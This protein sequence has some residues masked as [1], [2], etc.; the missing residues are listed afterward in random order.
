VINLN[1]TMLKIYHNPACK[2]SRAGL[3]F[4]QNTG[5]PFEVVAY[6]KNPITEQELEKLLIKL[7]K[8]P[9]EVVRTQEPYYKEN[10][11]GKNFGDHEW[12]RIILQN[13]KLLQRPIV[14]AAYKA[15]L[16]DPPENIGILL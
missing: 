3:Q 16:G 14:E 6:L 10:L 5:S 2:K 4:L 7:N 8:K 15:V 11:K 13:P 9:A 12:I 1:N